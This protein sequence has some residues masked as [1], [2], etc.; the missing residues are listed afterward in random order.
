[1]SFRITLSIK[2][3]PKKEHFGFKEDLM[4]SHSCRSKQLDK[5]HQKHHQVN[6]AFFHHQMQL[7]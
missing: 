7:L 5:H 1:M 6:Q 4:T 2:N 3:A